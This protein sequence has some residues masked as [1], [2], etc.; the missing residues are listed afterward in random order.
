MKGLYQ[1]K[2]FLVRLP[3]WLQEDLFVGD[4]GVEVVGTPRCMDPQEALR[5]CFTRRL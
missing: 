4:G 1:A 2:M 3:E 5:C